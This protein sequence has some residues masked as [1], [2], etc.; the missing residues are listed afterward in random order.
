MR[1][2]PPLEVYAGPGALE[3]LQRHGFQAGLFDYFVGASGG[4]KW[5]ALAGL[6]RVLFPEWFSYRRDPLHVIGSS[7]GAFRA[8][9]AAQ[10]DAFSAVNRLAEYYSTMVYSKKP[11]RFEITQK[12]KALITSLLGPSGGVDI[13]TNPV[14]KA[15]IIVARCH[16]PMQSEN[17]LTQLGGLAMS[18]A[19]N[20][21][22]RKRLS[23]LYTRSVFTSSRKFRIHDPYNL[24]TEY[25]DLDV[26]NLESAL[27]GSGSIPMVLEGVTRVMNAPRGIYRDGGIIDYHFDLSFGPVDGLVLYPHFYPKPIPGWFDK[28]LK[29]RVPHASSYHNTVMLVPSADFVSRLPYGKIPDRKDFEVL[30]DKSRITYWQT[31]L[32]ETDALGDYFLK[33]VGTGKI[34]DVIKPL[35]FDTISTPV[36]S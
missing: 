9:C 27:L 15:H 23:H 28:G 30:D 34:M 16:G 7:A 22:S 36:A 1:L 18:A 24:R 25:V 31:V 20:A 12:A 11:T 14:V 29:R 3:K 10:R 5:F 21:M 33:L 6:D 13:V 2:T 32:K 4:P 35:P 8:A 19:A 26:G 17:R